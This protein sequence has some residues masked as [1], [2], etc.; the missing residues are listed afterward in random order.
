MRAKRRGNWAKRSA[1]A[2]N[3]A[4][5]GDRSSRQLRAIGQE[6]VPIPPNLLGATPVLGDAAMGTAL[7]ARGLPLGAAPERWNLEHPDEVAAVH[8]AHVAAGA[9]WIQT[10]TFGG[11]RVRL[12]GRG[13]GAEV[14]RI[15]SAAVRC[16]RGAAGDAHVLGCVGPAG[17][18]PDGWDAAYAEQCEALVRHGVE[19]LVVET[20]L[21]LGEGTA[22]IRAAA[23]TGA[24]V[25][26]SFTPG[27]D[28]NL[29]DGTPAEAAAGCFVRTGASAIGVNCGFGPE[30]MLDPVR[31]LVATGLAPVLARP[32]AG[33]PE[34]RD[35]LACY[36]LP[37]DGFARAAIQFG[38][39]GAS[40]I[41]GCCGTTDQH[42]LA[43][44]LLLNART[45]ETRHDA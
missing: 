18:D 40:L 9:R 37:P 12:A 21:S 26:A 31:R 36:R 13:L 14:E 20:I 32:N 10:N 16:A 29:L 24:W 17:G 15:A 42:L 23:N 25:V 2:A 39:A 6:I 34:W 27:A 30:T 8:R 45:R 19:G 43:A 22:A 28:G 44:A 4:P 11:N 1:P 38:E 41:A 33:L 3:P 7:Q 35:G 5:V